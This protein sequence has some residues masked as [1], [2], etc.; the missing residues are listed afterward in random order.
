MERTFDTPDGLEAEVRIPSG[1]VR[2]RA[3]D[4]TTTHVVVEGFREPSDVEISL[5]PLPG[6]GAPP[7]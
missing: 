2:V 6:G 3:S 4:R 1:A 7:P 5:T